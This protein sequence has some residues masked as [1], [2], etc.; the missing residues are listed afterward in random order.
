MTTAIVYNFID[1]NLSGKSALQQN[2]NI[3]FSISD[4]WLP[5]IGTI[6]FAFGCQQYSFFVFNTLKNPTPQRWACVSLGGVS[7]AFLA[8]AL[9]GVFGF[10]AFGYKALP[11]ILDNLGN[12]DILANCTRLVLSSTMFLTFP[13]DFFVIRHTVY[14]IWKRF[15]H[16]NFACDNLPTQ[17]L[18]HDGIVSNNSNN[19][20]FQS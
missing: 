9:L 16:Q 18:L 12:H 7:G 4:Q 20:S 1:L 11:N 3:L 8:S 10:F 13:L 17:Q 19:V 6:A 15:C 14:T 5:A 2:P